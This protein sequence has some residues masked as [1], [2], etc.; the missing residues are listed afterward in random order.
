MNPINYLLSTIQSIAI[1]GGLTLGNAV[2]SRSMNLELFQ[3]VDRFSLDLYGA[4]QDGYLQRRAQAI[5]D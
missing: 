5:A 3:N 2:N 1:R 4:V